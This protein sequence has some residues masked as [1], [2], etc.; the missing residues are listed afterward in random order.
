MFK[1]GGKRTPSHHY[2]N[3]LLQGTLGYVTKQ[4]SPY[5]YLS[6]IKDFINDNDQSEEDDQSDDDPIP[7]KSEKNSQPKLKPKEK[8]KKNSSFP[9]LLIIII[10]SI[11]FVSICIGSFIFYRNF[12]SKKA[13]GSDSSIESEMSHSIQSKDHSSLK[14]GPK[15][16]G[17]QMY[18]V[19][20]DL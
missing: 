10:I 7:N 17:A 19:D 1:V 4:K 8:K 14:K 15:S 3:L 2:F 6:N 9:M 11:L 12:S 13:N 5:V 18:K 20:D 16:G